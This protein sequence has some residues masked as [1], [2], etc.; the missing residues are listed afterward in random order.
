[1][2]ETEPSATQRRRRSIVQRKMARSIALQ[3]ESRRNTAHV[4]QQGN[5]KEGQQ[6]CGLSLP[7]RVSSDQV[8]ETIVPTADRQ[9]PTADRRV[10]TTD[11][12]VLIANRRVPTTDCRVPTV[13]R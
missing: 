5:A 7:T 13:D 11:R 9:V 1:M 2:L 6:T 4:N 8:D 3:I 12:R 10:L